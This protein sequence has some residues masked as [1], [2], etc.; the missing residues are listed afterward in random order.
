M[1]S[2]LRSFWMMNRQQIKMDKDLPS[3]EVRS[4]VV[5]YAYLMRW[6]G[7]IDAL[8]WVTK[9]TISHALEDQLSTKQR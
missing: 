8:A 7:G 5:N 6:W 1:I 9:P 2:S 3:M 4:A